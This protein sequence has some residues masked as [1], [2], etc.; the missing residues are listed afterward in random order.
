[1]VDAIWKDIVGII[2]IT[3]PAWGYAIFAYGRR[4]ERRRGRFER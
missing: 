2:I 3:S 4:V 1:M